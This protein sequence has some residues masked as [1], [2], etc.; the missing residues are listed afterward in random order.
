MEALLQA[1]GK[2]AHMGGKRAVDERAA[3]LQH[4]A[5][6][7]ALR[8]P[9]PG[10]VMCRRHAFIAQKADRDA[11]VAEASDKDGGCGAKVVV[12][13]AQVEAGPKRLGGEIWAVRLLAGFGAGPLAFGADVHGRKNL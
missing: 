6:R 9:L 11:G 3:Q 8:G 1:T 5:D 13:G 4:A 2:R 10:R 7:Q 12:L